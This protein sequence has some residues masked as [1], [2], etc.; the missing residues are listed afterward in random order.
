M[1][2]SQVLGIW[3]GQEPH[4]GWISRVFEV[5]FHDMSRVGGSEN[6]LGRAL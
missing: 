3:S 4:L 5:C 2:M 6:D 1:T